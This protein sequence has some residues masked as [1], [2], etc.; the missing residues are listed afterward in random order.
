VK[1]KD[2]AQSKHEAVLLSFGPHVVNVMDP[3]RQSNWVRIHDVKPIEFINTEA[4][5]FL[6]RA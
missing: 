5:D 3:S 2:F 6:D 1:Q 4:L